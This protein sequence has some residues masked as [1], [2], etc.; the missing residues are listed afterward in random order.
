MS[1]KKSRTDGKFVVKFPTISPKSSGHTKIRN[2]ASKGKR[3]KPCSVLLLNIDALLKTKTVSLKNLDRQLHICK[4]KC[5]KLYEISSFSSSTASGETSPEVQEYAVV[6]KQ[7][8]LS[9]Q[10]ESTDTDSEVIGPLSELIR[11]T[12]S[13]SPSSKTDGASIPMK[14]EVKSD[15]GEEKNTEVDDKNDA[16]TYRKRGINYEFR[17]T[18]RKSTESAQTLSKPPTASTPALYDTPATDMLRQAISKTAV[19]QPSVF[20]TTV[21]NTTPNPVLPNVLSSSKTSATT[22]VTSA[23]TV[24]SVFGNQLFTPGNVNTK[25]NTQPAS[26]IKALK[27]EKTSSPSSKSTS[28]DMSIL[29]LMN[30]QMVLVPTDAVRQLSTNN[31]TLPSLTNVLGVPSAASSSVGAVLPM[32]SPVT[33]PPFAFLS[34]T[35]PNLITPAINPPLYNI[36]PGQTTENQPG[37]SN[38]IIFVPQ[39][40]NLNSQSLLLQSVGNQVPNLF[41]MNNPA[42][43]AIQIPNTP[44]PQ[45]QTTSVI[46]AIQASTEIKPPVQM[47]NTAAIDCTSFL[48]LTDGNLV[49]I[50]SDPSTLFHNTPVTSHAKSKESS[51]VSFAVNSSVSAVRCPVPSNGNKGLQMMSSAQP[52]YEQTHAKVPQFVTTNVP[53]LSV[54]GKAKQNTPQF[55]Q[56]LDGTL[57]PIAKPEEQKI[58]PSFQAS[59]QTLQKYCTGLQSNDHGLKYIN[60]DRNIFP[61]LQKFGTQPQSAEQKQL[62]KSKQ[63]ASN[64][65]QRTLFLIDKTL[66]NTTSFQDAFFQAEGSDEKKSGSENIGK[67]PQPVILQTNRSRQIHSAQLKIANNRSNT[68]KASHSAPYIQISPKPDLETAGNASIASSSNEAVIKPSSK[69]KSVNVVREEFDSQKKR[70]KKKSQTYFT[71]EVIDVD[72]EPDS[73]EKDEEGRSQFAFMRNVTKP[74]YRPVF[75]NST[76]EE[77]GLR[78]P[79][80]MLV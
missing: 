41:A 44:L 6:I 51:Q 65:S 38:P 78:L 34:P 50:V 66:K 59:N 14:V 16:F 79:D 7:E 25:T 8:P 75:L 5:Q 53:S 58:Q 56:L 43:P 26:A 54:N 33:Q 13:I 70:R 37:M 10:H 72:K 73:P 35:G 64:S 62:W 12:G 76:I 77:K 22:I 57:I 63:T 71:Q 28:G 49:P 32:V 42:T 18:K 3:C 45:Q 29:Q 48:R 24:P 68:L 20:S 30:G 23:S 46:P 47:P 17:I 9:P 36:L 21:S 55:I 69:R 61:V 39:A 1:G 4:E 80:N 40:G 67:K 52:V 15:A 60:Q 19:V 31:P 27:M 74:V 11:M 2:K